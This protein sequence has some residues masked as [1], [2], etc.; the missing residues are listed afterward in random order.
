MSRHLTT[1]KMSQ[2]HEKYLADVFDG[3][4]VPGS[5]SPWSHDAD[6]RSS[7][8]LV[9]AKATAN[10]S[11]SVKLPVWRKVDTEALRSGLTPLLALRIDEVDLITLHLHDFLSIIRETGW[12]K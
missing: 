8:F 5:G 7:K 6:V 4:V 2:E 12:A 10:Q 9:E 1:R 3:Q 11:M